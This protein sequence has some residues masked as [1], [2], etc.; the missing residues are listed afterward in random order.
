M[1]MKLHEEENACSLQMQD[2]T[3]CS[4]HACRTYYDYTSACAVSCNIFVVIDD[5][6]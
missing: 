6:I 2:E 1:P 5:S 4:Y 3:S